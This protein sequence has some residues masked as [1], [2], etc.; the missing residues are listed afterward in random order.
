MFFPKATAIASDKNYT[1]NMFQIFLKDL[2]FWEDNVAALEYIGV[3]TMLAIIANKYF[4]N[5]YKSFNKVS[6]FN[7]DPALIGYFA[8]GMYVYGITKWLVD[9]I[10][11]EKYDSIVFMARDGYL[12]MQAYKLFRKLYKELH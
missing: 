7:G 2:P 8:L 3:R 11:K 10:K 1:N 5:P 4:D 9:S 6:N 12:P